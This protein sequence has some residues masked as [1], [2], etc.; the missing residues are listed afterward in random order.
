[1]GKIRLKIKSHPP[2]SHQAKINFN[3]PSP[4]DNIKDNAP[5]PPS[6]LLPLRIGSLIPNFRVGCLHQA[7][8]VQMTLQRVRSLHRNHLTLILK[9][10]RLHTSY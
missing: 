10:C 4:T 2:P 9:L 5:P 3:L 6:S 7:Q 1:M 8:K